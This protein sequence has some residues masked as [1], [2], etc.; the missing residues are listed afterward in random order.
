MGMTWDYI[1]VCGTP[2]LNRVLDRLEARGYR[3][4]AQDNQVEGEYSYRHTDGAPGWSDWMY[5][6]AVTLKDGDTVKALLEGIR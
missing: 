2:A 5:Q 4:C 1:D 6:V 3:S